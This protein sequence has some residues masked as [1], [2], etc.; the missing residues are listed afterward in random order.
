MGFIIHLSVLDCRWEE[1]CGRVARAHYGASLSGRP[2]SE[3]RK[4]IPFRRCF[5]LLRASTV[6][7]R[8][9]LPPGASSILCV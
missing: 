8:C 2:V 4:P 1:T 3:V 5:V 9:S 7:A 6:V